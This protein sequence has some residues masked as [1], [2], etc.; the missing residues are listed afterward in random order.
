MKNWMKFLLIISLLTFGACFWKIN[1]KLD[2]IQGQLDAHKE[3][4][5]YLLGRDT[6]VQLFQQDVQSF[7]KKLVNFL[8]GGP[9]NGQNDK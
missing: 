7:L 8:T 1:Q 3:V 2:E 6:E 4:V 5:Q 9:D